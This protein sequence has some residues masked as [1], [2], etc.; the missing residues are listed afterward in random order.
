MQR[1]LDHIREAGE[2]GEDVGSPGGRKPL[3]R[4]HACRATLQQLERR[5]EIDGRLIDRQ[6][7][8]LM[9]PKAQPAEF[10]H[11]PLG[12][13]ALKASRWRRRWVTSHRSHMPTIDID[14][15]SDPQTLWK[16]WP[17]PPS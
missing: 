7:R 12:A 17:S 3:R 15:A 11:E 14:A 8:S 6:P 4:S 2:I 5:A 10:D 13:A 16:S 9:S 1:A